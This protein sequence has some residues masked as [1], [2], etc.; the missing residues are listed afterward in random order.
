M[1]EE[2]TLLKLNMLKD[3][4][5]EYDD[6]GEKVPLESFETVYLDF[7]YKL[8]VVIK[9]NIKA[10]NWNSGMHKMKLSVNGVAPF[11]EGSK[12][13]RDLND[14]NL[15]FPDFPEGVIESTIVGPEVIVIPRT[16]LNPPDAKLDYK[17]DG[18][19]ASFSSNTRVPFIEKI[20]VK[21]SFKI[22]QEMTAVKKEA[23]V[24]HIKDSDIKRIN[25]TFQITKLKYKTDNPFVAL[26]PYS[27]ESEFI[28]NYNEGKK[29][30][31]VLASLLKESYPDN[32]S[33]LVHNGYFYLKWQEYYL[34]AEKSRE[35]LREAV[36][37]TKVRP[38]QGAPVLVESE[39]P[40]RMFKEVY[41]TDTSKFF[42]R[43]VFVSKGNPMFILSG[44]GIRTNQFKVKVDGVHV[45]LS[46]YMIDLETPKIEFY[47]PVKRG[48]VVDIEY[49]SREAY[50]LDRNPFR[51]KYSSNRDTAE[52]SI[53][54]DVSVK[55]TDVY[56]VYESAKNTPFYRT[57]IVTNPILT[58]RPQGFL[59]IT[60]EEPIP[61]RMRAY[62]STDYYEEKDDVSVAT[63]V[64][65][66]EN[67]VGVS[68]EKLRIYLNGTY[69]ETVETTEDGTATY[70]VKTNEVSTDY[71]HVVAVYDSEIKG[72]VLLDISKVDTE[73]RKALVLESKTLA[74]LSEEEMKIK[75][76]VKDELYKKNLGLTRVELSYY[77]GGK[78]A[79]TFGIIGE[80]QVVTL[81]AP[82][83]KGSHLIVARTVDEEESAMTSIR[84]KVE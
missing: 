63:F 73:K 68:E 81:N 48:S 59:F 12:G 11:T 22:P 56:V 58:S 4:P 9:E 14:V 47:H 35:K 52:V 72:E 41:G 79:S 83:S 82:K 32:W 50:Y 49:L 60:D 77:D 18:D 61:F 33:P 27:S 84:I 16:D 31:L 23:P 26:Y 66:D 44:R 74:Y 65:E 8:R 34:Y 20:P 71:A 3:T 13:K 24:A 6:N 39:N 1:D 37:L 21:T 67:G 57:S 80:E 62:H 29:A 36:H 2:E 54:P 28:K 53:S 5:F 76:K 30:E 15:R 38:Q 75:V 70:T 51:T 19:K 10:R 40:N 64:L 69:K 17:I 25:S 43:E 45:P 46:E 78:K 7:I 42:T 55:D